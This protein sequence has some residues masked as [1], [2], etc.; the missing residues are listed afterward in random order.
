M[1]IEVVSLTLTYSKLNPHPQP[2]S[3]GEGS[4]AGVE[5]FHKNVYEHIN[6]MSMALYFQE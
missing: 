3:K 4:M 5:L 1:T 2:L 6:G